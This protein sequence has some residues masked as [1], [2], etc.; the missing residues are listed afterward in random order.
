MI[1]LSPTKLT[2][3]TKQHI[4]VQIL[5]NFPLFLRRRQSAGIG[6]GYVLVVVPKR[7]GIDELGFPNN[8]KQTP[9]TVKKREKSLESFVF[10]FIAGLRP[11]YGGG[12]LSSQGMVQVI[13]QISEN[14]E[15]ILEVY[16]EGSRGGI[17]SPGD[18]VDG[19]VVVSPAAEEL[20]GG[21]AD[22]FQGFPSPPGFGFRC[23]EGM[24]FMLIRCLH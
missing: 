3:P 7:F 16:V 4:G 17:G 15:F 1:H 23:E 18:I 24:G 21:T 22:L 2:I 13:H 20:F 19:C 9:V 10:L 8:F 5:P 14:A 11:F 12:N 6:G